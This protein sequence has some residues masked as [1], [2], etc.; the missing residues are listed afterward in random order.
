M[1]ETL[2]AKFTIDINNLKAG[3][4]TA[5]KLIRE[6]QSEFKTAAAGLDNWQKSETGLSAKIKSLNQIIPVQE[7][8]VKALK[9]QYQKLISNGLDPTSNRAIELRTQINREEAALE[10]N[11]KE[12]KDQGINY[13]KYLQDMKEKLPDLS[14][15]K[16]KLVEKYKDGFCEDKKKSKGG[17][18]AGII[19]GILVALAIIVF[20]LFK[21]GI[22]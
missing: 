5:N 16:E 19:I 3:L 10:S 21:F 1:A 15:I 4:N 7:Q 8:K 12:L 13:K 18:V 20:L 17:L 9:D 14:E 22:L 11:K 2:G 6:S